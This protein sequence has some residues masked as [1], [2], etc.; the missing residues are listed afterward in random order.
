MILI[1]ISV[2]A[3]SYILEAARFHRVAVATTFTISA[4]LLFIVTA[5]AARLERILYVAEHSGLCLYD[6]D[7]GHKFLRRIKLRKTSDYKGIC[8]S[9]QLGRL[10]LSSNEGDR[11]VCVDLSE[12]TIVWRK[13]YGR[14]P[15]SMAITPDG[16]RIYLPCRKEPDWSW[17]VIDAAR[18]DVITKILTEPG[19]QYE[20]NSDPNVPPW[21]KS[22]GPHNTWMNEQGSRVYFSSFTVPYVF[23]ADTKTNKI[24]G[25]VGPFSKGMRPF[26]VTRDERYV[27]ANVDGLLGFEVGAA[28][29]KGGW[30][31]EMLYRIEAQTP[32]KRVARL[33]KPL[34]LPHNVPSHG[35]NVRPDQNEVWVVDGFYGYVYIYDITDMPPR[36]LQ[37]IPLFARQRDKPT[38]GWISFSLDG[39]FAYPDDG[40]VINTE[41]KQVVTRIPLSEKLIEINFLNGKPIRAGHR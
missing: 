15:D 22:T 26:T 3:T 16:K 9:P 8:G 6:I 27:F 24:I 38:P 35:I 30:G 13:K 7:N 40:P 41:T 5:N 23:I 12:E 1:L 19:K 4:T 18:G 33:G 20:R 29:T 10:F 32:P 14:Y 36:F 11:L 28:R 34:K 17:W 39:K 2:R 37:Q 21:T 31:G 25:R